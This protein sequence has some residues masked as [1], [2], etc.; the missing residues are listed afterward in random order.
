MRQ[1][2]I[3]DILAIIEHGSLQKASEHRFVT[4]P[5]FSRRINVIE[6]YL[7]VPILNRATKPATVLPGVVAYRDRMQELSLA[8]KTLTNELRHNPVE[9]SKPVILVSQHSIT[10]SYSSSLLAQL[11]PAADEQITLRSEN[12]DA[13]Y[14]LLMTREADIAITYGVEAIP[15]LLDSALIEQ[16]QIG[17]DRFVPVFGT[18]H[19]R[20]LNQL[21]ARGELPIIGYPQEEFMGSIMRRDILPRVGSLDYVR[22]K[23]ETALTIAALHLA[24]AGIGV[25]WVPLKLAER[26][27]AEGI[28]TDMSDS[29][30]S[31][32]LHLIAQRMKGQSAERVDSVWQKLITQTATA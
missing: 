1:E 8:L 6:A 15:P 28:L 2:W 25:A 10:A 14:T 12:W 5:A 16:K 19:L 24:A 30:P 20:Q 27:I 32:T 4:Q 23:T 17:T 7:R 26:S 11:N 29:L 9:S 21:F 22:R 18:D 3:E 13:C 31:A